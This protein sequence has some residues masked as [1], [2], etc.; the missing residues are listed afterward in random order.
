MKKKLH[1]KYLFLT[2]LALFSLPISLLAYHPGAHYTSKDTGKDEE[3]D[4][5]GRFI[6][7]PIITFSPETSL[8]L[9]AIGIYFFRFQH[10]APGTRLSRISF[11]VSYTIRNQIRIRTSYEVAFDENKH[12]MTGQIS[13]SSFPLFFYGIG[14][15]TDFVD[16]ELIEEEYTT[17][18]GLFEYNYFYNFKGNFFIGGRY[19]FANSRLTEIEDIRIDEDN[20]N[21]PPTFPQLSPDVPPVIPGENGGTTSGFGLTMR[22]DRRENIFNPTKGPFLEGSLSTFQSFL[23]SDFTYT[24]LRV[25]ARHYK[26]VSNQRFVV[27]F[28]TLLER[29]F[30]VPSYEYTALL[31]GDEIMRGHFEGRFR[32]NVLLASQV[33]LRVPLGRDTWLNTT[34]K[35][36]KLKETFGLVFFVGAGD[37]SNT[38]GNWSFSNI[39]KSGGIGLRWMAD[40][41]ESINIRLDLA[42]GSQRPGFL[43]K[44]WGGVLT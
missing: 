35:D 9:G 3:E 11:P 22:Y 8:R 31:G 14:P 39:K 20:P 1:I 5:A 36:Y 38:L 23:G 27:A 12:V 4:K 28:Q 15:N 32:D 24:K 40:E 42:Y 33:E 7:L 6:V 44:Y 17:E 13:W 41:D 18:T 21:I 37:V 19:F 43:S 16:E 2:C 25:D 29:N 34:G 26:T 10:S 30:N